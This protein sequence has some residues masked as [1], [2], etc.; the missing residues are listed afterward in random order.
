MNQATHLSPQRTSED[1]FLNLARRIAG[2]KARMLYGRFGFTEHDVPDIGQELLLE[3]YR[4]RENFDPERGCAAAFILRI[5]NS[6]TADLIRY[7]QAECRDWRKCRR[8]LNEMITVPDAGQVE[9][10]DMVSSNSSG[11]AILAIDVKLAL[12]RLPPNLLELCDQLMNYDVDEI[13]DAITL[14]AKFMRG[15][16]K[17]RKRF[18]NYGFAE[19]FQ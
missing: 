19:K 15:L 14:H 4:R 10:I 12:E 2:K 9:L 18:L 7:R 3:I 6:K 5:A 8:S 17:L 1:Y 11:N 16:K 13:P